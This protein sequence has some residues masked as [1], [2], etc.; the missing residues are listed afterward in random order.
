MLLLVMMTEATEAYLPEEIVQPLLS[1][2]NSSSIKEALEVLIETSRTTDGRRDLASKS[3]LTAVLHLTQ[4]LRQRSETWILLLSLKLV[5]NLCAGEIVNQDLFIKQNGTKVI[6]AVMQTELKSSAP[7]YGIIRVGL[8]ILANV[9]LAGDKHQCPIWIQ[10]FPN[11]FLNLARLRSREAVDPLCMI[12]YA[13]CDVN[14]AS[15]AE[16]CSNDGLLLMAEIVGTISAG[17]VGHS[18][19]FQFFLLICM[20][21]VFNISLKFWTYMLSLI[22]SLFS[23]WLDSWFWRK[24]VQTAS[25][26]NML[27][28][29]TFA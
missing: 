2:S 29:I 20:P 3:I 4:E 6:S 1:S 18:F 23:D 12:I 21:L 8:Q 15:M 13:C 27:R 22:G 16:L 7:D 5:R 25:F 17:K 14:D 10:F 9:S 24:M 19:C 11:E 26:Q 28:R